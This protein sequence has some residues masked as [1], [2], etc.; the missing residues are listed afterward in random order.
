MAQHGWW[1]PEQDGEEPNLFGVWQ[2]SV[3]DLVPTGHNNPMGLAAPYKC[4]CCG[5]RPLGENLDVDM[6]LVWEKFG[7]LV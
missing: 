3:D 6:N 1:F 4:T 7:K 2:S 5:I